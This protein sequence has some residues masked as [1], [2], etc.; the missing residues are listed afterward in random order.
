[1]SRPQCIDDILRLG[2]REASQLAKQESVSIMGCR[3]KEEIHDRLIQHFANITGTQPSQEV[4]LYTY[5][6][7]FMTSKGLCPWLVLP[8]NYKPMSCAIVTNFS[9]SH[10]PNK[11]LCRLIKQ[12]L[13]DNFHWCCV[14]LV[15]FAKVGMSLQELYTTNCLKYKNQDQRF[16][17]ICVCFWF[18]CLLVLL[19]YI[20]FLKVF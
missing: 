1:M 13:F 8:K 3:T 19:V 5:L 4:I 20:V 16:I 15:H 2:I 6:Q 9:R 14:C 10:M 11:L 18:A 17:C 7:N 12:L